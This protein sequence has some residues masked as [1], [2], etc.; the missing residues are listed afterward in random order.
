LA[1]TSVLT[2]F[3]GRAPLI[4]ALDG[5]LMIV[6]GDGGL[7]MLLA[8]GFPGVRIRF[9]LHVGHCFKPRSSD[10]PSNVG[11]RERLVARLLVQ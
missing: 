1:T 11:Q 9:V 8:A 7:G 6:V 4:L 10:S 2:N 3:V 5:L